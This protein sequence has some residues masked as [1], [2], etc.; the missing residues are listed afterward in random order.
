MEEEGKK[1]QS[2]ALKILLAPPCQRFE[3]QMRSMRSISMQAVRGGL[4]SF[5]VKTETPPQSCDN[6]L[7]RA[8]ITIVPVAD[9]HAAAG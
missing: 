6:A 4:P 3:A 8:E 1:P 7:M 2:V 9:E 5:I